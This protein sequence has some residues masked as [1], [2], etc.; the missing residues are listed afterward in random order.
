LGVYINKEKAVKCLIG[1]LKEEYN[2]IDEEENNQYDEDFG[3]N[4]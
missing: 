4:Q 2:E 1:L 3:K